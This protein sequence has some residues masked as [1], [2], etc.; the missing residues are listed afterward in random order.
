MG[1][2]GQEPN[3]V[4][5]HFQV[6]GCA[7]RLCLTP[8]P[9][10]AIVRRIEPDRKFRLPQRKMYCIWA[11]QMR[12][13]KRED[14]KAEVEPHGH[15]DERGLRR[16]QW[17][18]VTV[19]HIGVWRPADH[20][21]EWCGSGEDAA[22]KIADTEVETDLKELMKGTLDPDEY[23]VRKIWCFWSRKRRGLM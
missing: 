22:R 23:V 18:A 21:G 6:C 16:Q 10:C 5:Q 19:Q 7:G 8:L 12:A 1:A 13:E 11:T 14:L 2:H 17:K 9:E 3:P 4:D 15:V 20:E